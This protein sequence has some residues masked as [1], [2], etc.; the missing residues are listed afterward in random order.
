MSC[1]SRD[2]L[3]KLKQQIAQH[4]GLDP[5]VIHLRRGRSAG[6]LKDEAKTLRSMGFVDGTLIFVG[7]GPVIPK[8][9]HVFRFEQYISETADD[10]PVVT[11]AS[12]LFSSGAPDSATGEGTRGD[13]SSAA[14]SALVTPKAAAKVPAK[15][16]TRPHFKHLFDM[17]LSELK[18]IRQ[19]RRMLGDR[20]NHPW[21]Q[22]RIREV[23][24][25]YIGTFYLD[26]QSLRACRLRGTKD[27]VTLAVELLD[28]SEK[29]TKYHKMVLCRRVRPGYPSTP[30]KK[31][32]IEPSTYMIVSKT[33]KIG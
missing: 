24:N 28:H 22:I 10:Q 23:K 6:M 8:D 1:D 19:V 12:G 18:T 29:L 15:Q 31:T 7:P 33:F 9:H 17:P 20:L 27:S 13:S 32:V 30:Q 14:P 2:T 3:L 21:D 11:P 25:S 5:D 16:K 26:G 4:L